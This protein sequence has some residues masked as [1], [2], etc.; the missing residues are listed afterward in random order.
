MPYIEQEKR[1]DALTKPGTPGELNYT[2]TTLIDEYLDN[3][4]FGEVPDYE[5][6]NSVVGV[7]ECAKLEFYSRLVAAYE[8]RKRAE[9]GDVYSPNLLRCLEGVST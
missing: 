2:I 9:N 6:L 5:R 8:D 1:L 3:P 4:E 7:L